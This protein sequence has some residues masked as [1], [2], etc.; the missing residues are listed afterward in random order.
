MMMMI[1]NDDVPKI[2]LTDIKILF[3]VLTAESTVLLGANN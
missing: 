2:L 1:K 3:P